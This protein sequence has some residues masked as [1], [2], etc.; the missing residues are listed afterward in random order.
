MSNCDKFNVVF[1]IPH[2]L[3]ISILNYASVVD[4][5]TW[6]NP[7][8]IA[9]FW[10]FYWSFSPGASLICGEKCFE[11]DPQY[12]V[13]I[14]PYFCFGS[15]SEGP[16]E[17]FYIHFSLENFRLQ[18]SLPVTLT[19]FGAPERAE[20]KKR[21]ESSESAVTA[22]WLNFLICKA[23][24]ELEARSGE[25][26]DDLRTGY[27]PRIVMALKLMDEKKKLTNSEIARRIGMSTDNFIRLFKNEIGITPK[28]YNNSR[29]MELAQTL[30]MDKS[31]SIDEIAVRCGFAD[32]Y[33]FSKQFTAYYSVS[34]GRYRKHISRTI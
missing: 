27:D 17:Q 13:L 30:L 5:K 3:H 7:D 4:L 15:R 14:P 34:P 11:L 2:Q 32:R 9:P 12:P 8:R 24:M 19:S 22:V 29:R 18:P 23:L 10:R 25:L 1:N 20:I 28:S 21:F 6:D 16:L 31:L 33:Q 26:V